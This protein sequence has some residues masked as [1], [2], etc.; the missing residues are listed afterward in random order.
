MTSTVCR[1]CNADTQLTQVGHVEG[2]DSGI[3]V[4]LEGL[5]IVECTNSHKRFP[6][7]GYPLELIQALLNK[8]DVVT[9]Q[10]AVEKGL[11]RKHRYCPGC[12]KELSAESGSTTKSRTEV[13]LPNLQPVVVEVALPLYRCPGC[14][15]D[16]TLPEKTVAKA[17]MQAVANAFRS[18]DIPPG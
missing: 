12:G 5:S 9:T 3:R 18:A 6:T 13:A 4:V 1:Q 17:I 16:A 15:K 2:E 7:P 8:D 10:F 11:F 14:S